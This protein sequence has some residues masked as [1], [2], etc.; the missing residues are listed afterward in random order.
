V[1]TVVSKV[2]SAGT[3]QLT[4]T[5]D[6]EFY[7]EETDRTAGIKVVGA[8]GTVQEGKLVT[9]TGRVTTL[10]G[11]RRIE[12]IS[13]EILP[14]SG[15]VPAPLGMRVLDVGGSALNAYTPGVKYGFGPNNIGLLIKTWGRVIAT[16]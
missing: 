13:Y 12:I 14:G 4:G 15:V 10:A 8:A 2:V 11:E 7:I 16:G 6:V 9:I 5:S 1:L 3:D